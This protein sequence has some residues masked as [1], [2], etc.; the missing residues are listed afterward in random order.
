MRPLTSDV[1]F[2]NGFPFMNPFTFQSRKFENRAVDHN[3][4]SE[5][6]AVTFDDVSFNIDTCMA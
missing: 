6:F 5:P 2:P 3:C 1:A 4:Y